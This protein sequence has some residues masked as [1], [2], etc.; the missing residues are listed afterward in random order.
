MTPCSI[1]HHAVGHMAGKIHLMGDDQHRAALP[2]KLAHNDQHLAGQL[3]VKRRGRLVKIEDLGSA[4]MA[5][6]MATR[7]C[8]PPESWLG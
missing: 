3:R 7:C 5:R 6:A 8:C 2:R 1:K 4:A